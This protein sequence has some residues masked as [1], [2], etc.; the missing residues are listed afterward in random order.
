MN[1][2]LLAGLM[3]LPT[4]AM[5]APAITSV[6]GTVSDDQ[7][8]T[9]NGSGFGTN[10]LR[11][12]WLGGKS[13]PIEST[14]AGTRF[15]ATARAGWSEDGSL[16]ESFID[17]RRAYSGSRSIVFD[18]ALARYRDGRF[19]LIYD[20][21]SNFTE[22]YSS[23]MVYFDDGGAGA[24]Q[25]K[26][27]R[28]CFKN[29]VTDDSVPNA[30]V[31]NCAGA[32]GDFFYVQGGSTATKMNW[33]DTQSLPLTGAWYR[34]ETY[35]RPSSSSTASDGE[36]W[37]RTTKVSDGTTGTQRYTGLKTYSDGDTNRYRYIVFQNYMGNGNYNNQT[38]VWMDD[39]YISQTQARVE[40]CKSSTW[41]ACKNKDIQLPTAWNNSQISVKLNQGGLGSLSGTYLYVV[42]SSG[43]VN[44][45]GFPL[46]AGAAAP[47]APTNIQAVPQ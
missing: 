32:P 31:S 26:M 14:P 34:V 19:G 24:G 20:T 39:I 13:G 30:Y 40:L 12:Q 5:A 18:P 10:S 4:V 28:W 38:I 36:F 42:D 47:S 21:G 22:L 7:T 37:M 3:L 23:N 16:D 11:Q 15:L 45:N 41:A 27:I 1:R 44:A 33:F 29:S 17:S 46:V 35:M 25:W 43:N 8:I 9:I 2:H 6:T